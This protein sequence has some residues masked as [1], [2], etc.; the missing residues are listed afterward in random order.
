MST[1]TYGWLM[2]QGGGEHFDRHLFA[3]AIS[4]ALDTPC[5]PLST[6]LGLSAEALAALVGHFFPHAPK[7]LAGLDPDDESATPRTAVE[8]L[9]RNLL[10]SSRTNNLIEQDWL[11]HII[12]RRALMSNLLWQDLGLRDRNQLNLL[13]ARHF[14]VLAQANQLDMRW[15]PFFWRE[16]ERQRGF[17]CRREIQCHLCDRFSNCF[18]PE[19]GAS[20]LMGA[21]LP[22]A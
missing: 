2:A 16:L 22:T 5:N 19:L 10:L 18:G 11:S 3:C 9:L 12:A 20:L 8:E 13:M 17:D 1:Q 6:S 14:R 21:G 4:T 7:L 15:K